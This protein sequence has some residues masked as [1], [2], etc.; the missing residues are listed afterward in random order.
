MPQACV[1]LCIT[2]LLMDP[3]TLPALGLALL[4]RTLLIQP[5]T[6]PSASMMPTFDVG[7]FVM[8][9]KYNYGY[10][11]FSVPGI[12]RYLPPFQILRGEP[13][14]GDVVIFALPSDQSID[15]V[16]RV[17]GVAGDHVQMIKGITYLNGKP[18]PRVRV[19]AYHGSTPDYDGA[20]IYRE[21][22]PDGTSYDVME[23]TDGSDG[24]NTQEYIVPAGHCFVLGD[25]RD[26][27]VDSRYTVGYVPYANIYA[28]AL[29]K[30]DYSGPRLKAHS[31]R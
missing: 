27:S 12:G 20:P 2:E 19:A 1:A 30:V 10:D 9:T 14:R 28:K 5:F 31:V 11:Q 3:F 8:T 22:L 7:D 18:L 24:D 26:N 13:K 15:Y 21:T 4:T 17:I 6:I 25:N 16:K 23:I 29:I